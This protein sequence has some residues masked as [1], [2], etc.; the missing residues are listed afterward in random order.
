MTDP[1]DPVVGQR[2]NGFAYD[3][4]VPNAD[5]LSGCIADAKGKPLPNLA[6]V[7]R[8]L[9][10]D[11]ALMEAFAYDEMLSACIV[12]RAIGTTWP[13][14]SMFEPRPATDV[15]VIEL[16]E[17]LQNAGLASVTKN[18]AHSAVDLR[19]S[20]RAF[21]PVRNYLISLTWD[22]HS[23]LFGWLSEYFRAEQSAYT[24]KIG[25]MFLI[26]MVARIMKPGCKSDHMVVLEGPQGALKSTACSILGGDYFSDSLPDIVFGKDVSQHLRGKWLIEVSEMHALDKTEVALLKAFLSRTTERYRPSYGHKEVIEP[27]Q[28]AFIG[29]TN[30]ATY[31]RD[32][33]GGR[34]FWPVPTGTIDIP[35]LIR[36]RDQLFAEALHLFRAGAPWWPDRSFERE[37]IAPQQASRYE[38]DS[39]EEPIGEF[40]KKVSRVTVGMVAL[41]ALR[42]EA[43]KIG[44]ADQNRITA[45]ME[46]IGWE[47]ERGGKADW[48]GKRWWVKS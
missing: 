30:R 16:Q 38:A 23:R 6:N 43:K 37:F 3:D 4:N 10:S 36:D 35:A 11:P 2:I 48:Q 9:R 40:L 13:S 27:R 22:G 28:C 15:D 42:L 5:W 19:A 20:E 32:E 1:E 12:T 18:T 29:T 34:R 47:R 24:A 7:M 26:A 17:W 46:R 39:W 45:A 44:R 41:D 25:E 21:H 31:L 14:N 33:T 8:A